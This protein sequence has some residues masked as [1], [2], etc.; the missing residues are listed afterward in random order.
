MAKAKDVVTSVGN[1]VNNWLESNGAEL[2]DWSVRIPSFAAGVAAL[3]WAGANMTVATTAIAAIV[4]G[5][6]VVDVLKRATKRSR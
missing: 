6:K 5:Q 2:V 4:G 1:Q 3:G